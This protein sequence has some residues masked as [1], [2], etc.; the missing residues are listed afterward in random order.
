MRG[1]PHNGLS[2]LISRINRRSSKGIFGRPHRGLDRQRQNAWKPARCHR[3]IDSGRMMV[4]AAVML[5][6]SR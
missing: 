6:N 1:A 4:T 3:T 2:R 5:G